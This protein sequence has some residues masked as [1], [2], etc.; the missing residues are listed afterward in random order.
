[1]KQSE[2][3]PILYK[4]QKSKL[5]DIPIKKWNAENKKEFED[6]KK[7]I[8]V[9]FNNKYT[10]HIV[11]QIK[12]IRLSDGKIYDSITKA[13]VDNGYC[14]TTFLKLLKEEKLFKKI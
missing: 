1:M 10:R 13:R 2:V 6:L 14:K 4:N 11:N 7:G 5:W 3:I 9:E 12:T 8:I